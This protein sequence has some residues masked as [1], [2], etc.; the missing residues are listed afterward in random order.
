M[1]KYLMHKN[2][3]KGAF[4]ILIK[5]WIHGIPVFFLVQTELGNSYMTVAKYAVSLHVYF[6]ESQL[7]AT[8]KCVLKS[9]LSFYWTE[10]F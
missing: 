3:T 9:M 2:V 6:L 7:H 8:Q 10:Q 4:L 1:Y 5:Y